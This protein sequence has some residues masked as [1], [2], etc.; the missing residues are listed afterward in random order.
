VP[1]RPGRWSMSRRAGSRRNRPAPAP[2]APP[3]NASGW[4]AFFAGRLFA[5]GLVGLAGLTGQLFGAG[6]I[7]A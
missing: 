2:R 5:V 6:L 7:A 4:P 1:P 3:A